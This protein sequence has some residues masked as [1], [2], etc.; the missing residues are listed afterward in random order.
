M[1]DRTYKFSAMV[2]KFQ[3][4]SSYEFPLSLTVVTGRTKEQSFSTFL[5]VFNFIFIFDTAAL[6]NPEYVFCYKMD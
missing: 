1:K 5:F 6:K 2:D 4:Q 3:L